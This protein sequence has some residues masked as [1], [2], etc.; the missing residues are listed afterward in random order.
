M[1]LTKKQALLDAKA[2]L[3]RLRAKIDIALK[4][5]VIVQ[6]RYSQSHEF[7]AC[8]RAALDVKKELN[9]LTQYAKYAYQN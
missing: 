6:E 5:E 3:D 7:A 1:S 9:K 8:V 4:S 2:E